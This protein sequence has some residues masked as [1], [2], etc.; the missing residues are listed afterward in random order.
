MLQSLDLGGAI[1]VFV[2]AGIVILVAGLPL[3]RLAD[4]LADASGLGEAVVGA[5]VLGAL[6]SL[7]GSVTSVLAA[8]DGYPVLAA[9]NAIGGIVA[10]TAFLAL[11]DVTYRSANLEHAAASPANMVSAALLIGLLSLALMA[12]V[13]PE[14]TVAHVHPLS[15]ALIIVYAAGIRLTDSIRKRPTWEPVRT[16]ETRE[17][18]PA[19]DADTSTRS[20][21]RLA[22]GVVVLGCLTALA[23]VATAR[24]GARLAELTGMEEGV[25]GA[26][27]TAISTSTPE[28]V[29][30]L[31][32]VRRG[33][34]TLAV[35]G[36]IG[37]NVFDV[38][39]LAFSDMAFF[40]GSIYHAVTP[41]QQF[42]MLL[43]I[44]MT[45]CLL[46]G[47]IR[48]E[49]SGP[50]NIGF[51]TVTLVALYLGGMWVYLVAW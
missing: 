16:R 51:E 8:V 22:A 50:A 23:G 31:A 48:R 36:I 37:G 32:A 30:T 35:A 14:V 15:I 49:R 45:A 44:A 28:L 34:L 20:V 29:V 38:L 21:I 4:K 11:A 43:A 6:T 33:A 3:T 12:T 17:D 47:M 39:F 13:L 10:Q 7:G 25:V 40:G 2:G 27:L 26:L 42:L 19:A 46:L 5:V 18:E 24:S 41:A 1:A 9:S